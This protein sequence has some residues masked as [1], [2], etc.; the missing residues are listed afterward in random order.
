MRKQNTAPAVS[1]EDPD[2]CIG[3]ITSV[4]GV[5]GYVK[6]RTFTNKP[7]DVTTFQNVFDE[8]GNNYKVSVVFPKKDYLIAS[9]D[10][11]NN[12]N[13]AEPL[14]NTKLYIKRSEL[15]TPKN[16][17]FYHADLVGM[18]A[19]SHDGSK[20]GIV[21]NVVNFGAG[22]ILEIYDVTS[23]KVVYYPF[24]KQYVPVIDIVERYITVNPL[25]E[26]IAADD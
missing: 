22:D 14:R 13:Q 7:S 12:R 6:I 21:K 1:Q 9:L 4:H 19:R 20:F 16:N 26:V 10:G 15:P 11:I 5:K 24:K 8:A 2:I 25:E 23:E 3:V 17:E 18:E